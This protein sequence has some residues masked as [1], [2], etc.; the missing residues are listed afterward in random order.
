MSSDSY[1]KLNKFKEQIINA[2]FEKESLDSLENLL[3][4]EHGRD[5]NNLYPFMLQKI[6]KWQCMD[7][8]IEKNDLNEAKNQL[9]EKYERKFSENKIKKIYS[10]LIKSF[11][12]GM[13][14]GKK[15]LN[16]FIQ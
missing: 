6:Y 11:Y 16:Q 10:L 9:K 4:I 8:C 12:E 5:F 7:Y 1:K 3:K 14:K 2:G 13:P 15:E